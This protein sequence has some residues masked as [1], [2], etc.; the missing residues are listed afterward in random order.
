[1]KILI[2]S[3]CHANIDALNALW[4]Q[5]KS[6]DHIIFAGDMVDFGFYPKE[7]VHWFMDRKEMLHA[8]RGNHDEYIV[9]HRQN[10]VSDHQPPRNFQELTYQQLSEEEY[11][12]LQA[13]PH[14]AS[15][16]IGDTDF[17]L[18][19]CPDELTQEVCYPERLLSSFE[20]RP[21]F[22]ERFATK[23]PHSSSHKKVIVYGHSHIPWATSV[24]ADCI[25]LNPGSLSYRFGG[26]EEVRCSD[27]IVWEDGAISFRHVDFD[28][29]H[30]YERAQD[31]EDPE[32][33]RLAHAFYRDK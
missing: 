12:F 11:D 8:V 24:G 30:L 22:L 16:T 29:S 2:L 18:C 27:Y 13:I 33:I 23:F 9:S 10:P 21:F 6:C 28:T 20:V 14:E 4:T 25:L 19:H 26:L 15:F 31:F 17:Y 7:A 1:M 3:D 5:E 32:A